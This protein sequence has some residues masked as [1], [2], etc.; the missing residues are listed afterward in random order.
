[1]NN[2]FV[3]PFGR[4]KCLTIFGQNM[5]KQ[6]MSKIESI[7]FGEYIRTLRENANIPLRKVAAEL[8]IDKI[9]TNNPVKLDKYAI[10]L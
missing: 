8:D 4:K 7:S 10:I 6:K 9:T 2:F 3:K 5:P 1:M